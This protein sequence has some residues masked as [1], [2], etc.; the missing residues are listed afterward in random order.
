MGTWPV[1]LLSRCGD[2]S[3]LR[4]RRSCGAAERG[5]RRRVLVVTSS[6]RYIDSRFADLR[7][8]NARYRGINFFKYVAHSVAKFPVPIMRLKLA[9]V[10]DPPNVVADAI[11]FLV[12]PV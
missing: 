10:A 8:R 2:A 1:F 11:G 5:R 6:N 7:S 12:A 3:C 9:Y 4:D